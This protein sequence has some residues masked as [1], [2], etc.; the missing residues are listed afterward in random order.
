MT[1][2]IRLVQT[3]EEYRAISQIQRAVWGKPDTEIIPYHMPII[4]QKEGGLVLGA[5]ERSPED[6][7]EK[8]IGFAFGFVGLTSE[9]QVKHCSEIAGVLPA[10]QNR[11]VGYRLK[12]AQRERVL[13]QGIDLIT[14]TFDPLESRNARLNIHKLGA[15]CQTYLRNLYGNLSDVLN[16]GLPS[17]R[18]RVD[19]RIGSD[20]VA[21]RLRG[22]WAGSSAE[23][24]PIINPILP[25]DRSAEQSLPRPPRETLPIAGD[26]LLIQIPARF[27]AI[28]LAD[29]DLGLAWREHTRTLF[30]AAFAAGYT[31]V[32]LLFEY[33]QSYYLLQQFPIGNPIYQ[34]SSA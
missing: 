4:F 28:K 15:T 34:R 22:D 19:W 31:V 3:I 23:G 16:A 1:I 11:N 12:L 7:K 10:Y 29:S 30:E 32:D 18:F 17:D 21:G 6:E 25:G 14:W 8:L 26:Q 5:F 13:A 24:I 27:Q 20:H 33:G 2:E 9:G